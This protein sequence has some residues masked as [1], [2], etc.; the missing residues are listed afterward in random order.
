MVRIYKSSYPDY[1]IPRQS[2]VSKL[3]SADS[4]Y[5]DS[6]PAFIE[7]ATGRTLSRGDIKDLS[8]RLGYGV[9]NSLKAHRGDTVMIFR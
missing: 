1:V 2:V 8:L 6:L 3:F 5:D 7:A 9:R 4:P